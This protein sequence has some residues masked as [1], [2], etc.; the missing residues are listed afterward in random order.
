MKRALSLIL[1]AILALSLTAC[2]GGK[3]AEIPGTYEAVGLVSGPAYVL[4]ENGS[5]DRGEEKGTYTAAEDGSGIVLTPK[6]GT[7]YSLLASGEYYYTETAMTEDTEYGMAPSFDENGHADQTFTTE[8][9]GSTLT[10]TMRQDGSYSFSSS[11]PSAVSS[12]LT[13]TVSYDGSYRL[14]DTVLY[15]NWNEMDFPLLFVD[16]AIYPVVY[17]Q[18]TDGNSADISAKQTAVQNAEKEAADSRWWTP[19]DDPS[20]LKSALLGTWHYTDGYGNYDLTFSDSAVSV[21]M[22]F[23][24]YTALDATGTYTILQDA[25]LLEYQSQS[26]TYTIINHRAVPFT[27]ENGTLTLYEML[28]VM[29][30]DGLLDPAADLTSIASYQYQKTTG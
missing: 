30:E 6:D 10:L 12:K 23:L 14:E 25:V 7:A 3:E 20:E 2:G 18:K 27:F 11:K 17:L 15:L 1:I 29:N 19:S 21:H 28:D 16:D 9:E 8:A 5:F 22:D 13:D 4:N 26:G 24:G